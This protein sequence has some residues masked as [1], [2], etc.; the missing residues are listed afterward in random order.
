MP[1]ITHLTITSAWSQGHILLGFYLMSELAILCEISGTAWLIWSLL[2]T[3]KEEIGRIFAIV[4]RWKRT[5]LSTAVDVRSTLKKTCNKCY[6]ESVS[7]C[8][9]RSVAP[10][11]INRAR[12]RWKCCW[13][14]R[15][16]RKGANTIRHTHKKLGIVHG[17]SY[18]R[19]T[20]TR[21]TPQINRGLSESAHQPKFIPATFLSL[22]WICEIHVIYLNFLFGEVFWFWFG[23]FTMTYISLAPCTLVLHYFTWVN[24]F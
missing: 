15:W 12:L 14:I 2:Q 6:S 8:I 4:N 7:M 5:E 17:F 20:E 1:I 9:T 24:P 11:S 16:P 10:A 22:A 18:C 13:I 23:T 3:T 21:V 19:T